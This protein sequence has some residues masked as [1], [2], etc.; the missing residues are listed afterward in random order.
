MTT[1][2]LAL[3]RASFIL[4]DGRVLFS[5]LSE[6]FDTRRSGLVGRNGAGKSV[7]ARVLAGEL[8]PTSGRCLRQAPV[9]YLAQHAGQGDAVNVAALAG[10]G[11]VLDALARIEAGSTDP[12]DFDAVGE[13]WDLPQRLA[14]E[15]ARL[16]L[17]GLAPDTPASSLSGGQAMRVAL[18]GAALLDPGYLILDEPSNHLDRAARHALIDWLLAWRKGMLVISHDRE[19]LGVMERILELSPQGLRSYGGDF[20]FYEEARRVEQDSAAR[21]LEEARLA[22]RRDEQARRE[23]R[24]RQDK[25]QAQGRR[26]GKQANQ[27]AIL[28]GGR[29][30][31]SEGS[32]GRLRQQ[33]EAAREEQQRQVVEAA[34]RV[35]EDAAVRIHAAQASAPAGRRVAALEDVL[36]PYARAPHARISLHLGGRQRVGILGPNGCGKSTLLKVLAGELAPLAGERSLPAR[37]AWLDQQFATLDP[38]RSTLDQLL[39]L[40]RSVGQDMLRTWL[41][42]LGLDAATVQRPTGQLSGGERLK[43]ALAC[44]LYAEEPP[45]L[46]LLDEP[47]NHLDLPS[48]AALEAM[49]NGFQGALAV[50]SHDRVFLDRIGLTHRLQAGPDGWRLDEWDGEPVAVD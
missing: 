24:E 7:L 40:N 32:S 36:L 27:A 37:V 39:A 22:L 45:Q 23:Q 49:L 48:L 19:L 50:V 10:V 3:E 11:P 43:A 34:G 1:T 5:D 25:R 29:K 38:A 14:Q 46:L 2:I 4:P 8:A 9:F 47:G 15:L 35:R 21:Q 42:Q 12:A 30:E 28:L 26:E 44:A 17:P 13:H 18:A 33:H 31:R 16:G 41:V 6:Q 20:A